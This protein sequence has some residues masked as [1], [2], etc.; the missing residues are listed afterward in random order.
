VVKCVGEK[1]LN[2]SSREIGISAIDIGLCI[3]YI[4]R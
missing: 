1:D 2:L 4:S 3:P